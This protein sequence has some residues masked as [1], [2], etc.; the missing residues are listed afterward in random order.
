[1]KKT[2]VL[3]LLSI[4][5]FFGCSRG[6]TVGFGGAGFADMAQLEVM[7][8]ASRNM[9]LYGRTTNDSMSSSGISESAILTDFER[10]LVRNAY[11][12]IRVENLETAN[13]FVLDLMNRFNAYAAS[14]TI[15]ENSYYYSIRVPS[16]QY[17]LFLAEINGIGRMI[18]R[19]ENTED[20]TLRYYDLAGRLETQR[21]LL[22]TFQSYLGR[23][24]NIDEIL[25]VE[26]RIMDLQ[27]EIEW[28]GSQLRHLA[29][30]VDYSTIDL[31]L[32]GPIT[33]RSN[34]SETFPER[35]K[36][37]FGNFGGFF[38]IVGVI[39]LGFIIYG[40]PVLAIATLLFWVLFGR[41]GLLKKLWRVVMKKH[42]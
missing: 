24:N 10:K 38:S 25:S 34:M 11:I 18:Q 4:I 37:L 33:A 15:H 20:V 8:T 29:N 31:N 23:A 19:T 16:N 3:V 27:R 14:T 30:Q 6:N 21:E 2:F 26:A 42:E 22:R 7:P 41:I 39:L 5:L 9:S 28:V 35:T 36:R 17:D 32:L 1:M 13:V 40:I 12:S